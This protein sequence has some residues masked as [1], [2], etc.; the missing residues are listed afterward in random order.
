MSNRATKILILGG[1]PAGAVVAVGLARL[2]HEPLLVSA[3]V[4]TADFL[5][6][7]R[8][9]DVQVW[10]PSP[11]FKAA[12]NGEPEPQPGRLPLILKTYPMM[13]WLWIG[14]AIALADAGITFGY[15]PADKRRRN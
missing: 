13:T 9:R 11:E 14:F 15:T 2:G 4:I 10:F 5:V 12:E 1:G 3:T 7:A 6:E 8:G